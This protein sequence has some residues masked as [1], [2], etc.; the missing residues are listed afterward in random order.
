MHCWFA[1]GSRGIKM[2]IYKF[3]CIWKYDDLP[4]GEF[5][6]TSCGD[7]FSFEDGGGPLDH[8][9]EVCPFCGVEIAQ[10]KPNLELQPEEK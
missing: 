10:Q 7:A 2:T 6:M 4:F 8:G 3:Y 1:N 5:W 9:F